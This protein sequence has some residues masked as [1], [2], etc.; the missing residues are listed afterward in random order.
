MQ[1]SNSMMLTF[2]NTNLPHAGRTFTND[3]LNHCHIQD[4]ISQKVI[5]G[6]Q[7]LYF[8][9]ADF[10]RNYAHVQVQYLL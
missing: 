5:F 1:I 7:L 2:M 9:W 10:P 4:I 3:Q 8:Y 6:K